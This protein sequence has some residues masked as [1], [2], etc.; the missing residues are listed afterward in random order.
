MNPHAE[1]ERVDVGDDGIR[2]R[3]LLV[4]D[5][6]ATELLARRRSDGHELTVPV[7]LDGPSFDVT[8]PFEALAWHDDDEPDFWDLYIGRLRLGRHRDGVADKRHAYVFPPHDAE[9]RRFR[10][11]YTTQNHLFI[12]TG[13]VRPGKAPA[14]PLPAPPA[15]RRIVPPHELAVHRLAHALAGI[16]LRRRPQSGEPKVTILIANAYGM[17]GTVRTCLNVAGYLAQRHRVEIIS[18]HRQRDRP[19]FPFPTGVKVRVVDDLRERP[20]GGR[21][22][23]IR[24]LLRPTAAASC[25]PA[26]SA[27]R[28]AARCG[29]TCCCC[30]TCGPCAGAL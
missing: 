16:V 17:G 2:I 3:G 25:T 9:Q 26:T 19:F 21:A 20:L 12:R 7:A 10:P 24:D 23:R 8:V 4:G 29:R 5:D 28:A 18:V 11:F 1:V 15:R 6:D 30:A 27:S 13:P 14:R 22:G